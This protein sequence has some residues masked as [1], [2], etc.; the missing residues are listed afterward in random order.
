MGYHHKISKQRLFLNKDKVSEILKFF[1]TRGYAITISKQPNGKT[2][3]SGALAMDLVMSVWDLDAEAIVIQTKPPL[4][5]ASNISINADQSALC[6]S[7]RDLQG[8]E[9]ILM[10]A[11]QDM[12]NL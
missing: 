12:V 6:L 1:V 2:E 10:Y 9:L 8:R 4:Q 3:S 7:G 5:S 11:F